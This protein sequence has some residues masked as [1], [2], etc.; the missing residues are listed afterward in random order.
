MHVEDILTLEDI[1]SKV[2]FLSNSVT[3]TMIVEPL[4]MWLYLVK[5]NH[6]RW[7]WPTG[8]VRPPSPPRHDITALEEPF[9]ARGSDAFLFYT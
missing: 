1:L 6:Y 9:R 3:S 4:A 5:V 8:G 7:S 2:I